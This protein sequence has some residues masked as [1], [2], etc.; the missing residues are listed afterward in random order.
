M[1][2]ILHPKWLALISS[3]LYMIS[4]AIAFVI[5]RLSA[6]ADTE[7]TLSPPFFFPF[8]A[9]NDIGATL[10]APSSLRRHICKDFFWNCWNMISTAEYLKMLSFSHQTRVHCE[11]RKYIILWCRVFA[12]L[13]KTGRLLFNTQVWS[14][15]SY[16][17]LLLT[18]DHALY[19]SRYILV[20]VYITQSIIF[21]LNFSWRCAGSILQWF[22]DLW[23]FNNGLITFCTV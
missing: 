2:C 12:T 14:T 17:C 3:C 1:I 7:C 21:T 4:L 15:T 8:F 23:F 22:R 20:P 6:C 13:K 9:L 19:I 16:K 10:F 11:F 5:A 18:R